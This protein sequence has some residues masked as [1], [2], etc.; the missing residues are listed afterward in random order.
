MSGREPRGDSLLTSTAKGILIGLLE[1]ARN[2]S[3]HYFTG[4]RLIGTA[5]YSLFEVIREFCSFLAGSSQVHHEVPLTIG[6]L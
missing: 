6:D 1:G 5:L 2:V 4:N 3:H